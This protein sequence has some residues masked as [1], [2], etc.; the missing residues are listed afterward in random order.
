MEYISQPNAILNKRKYSQSLFK[1]KSLCSL[2]TEWVGVDNLKIYL[3]GEKGCYPSIEI[4]DDCV[5]I[6]EGENCCTLTIEEWN[7]LKNKII[8]GKL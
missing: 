1:F 2:I 3:C 4:K 7:E 5:V 8:N 6:G